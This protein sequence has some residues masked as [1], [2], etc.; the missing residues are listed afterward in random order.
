MKYGGNDQL[1]PLVLP[2]WL[3]KAIPWRN[4]PK[5]LD[6]ALST[7]VLALPPDN[8]FLPAEFIE[9]IRGY[10]TA[11]HVTW[12]ESEVWRGTIANAI[13]TALRSPG[14]HYGGVSHGLSFSRSTFHGQP[15]PRIDFV[16]LH[17]ALVALAGSAKRLSEATGE[18]FGVA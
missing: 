8:A 6:A 9:A 15:I 12:V 1:F 7:A 17:P 5:N 16:N 11:E 2:S 14:V 18:W 13:Y 10:V 4:A 3:L